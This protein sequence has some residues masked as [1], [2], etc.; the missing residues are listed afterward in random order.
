MDQRPETRSDWGVGSGLCECGCGQPAPI[1]KR[2]RREKGHV[3]GFP[4]RFIRGHNGRQRDEFRVEDR[5][6]ETPCWIWTKSLFPKTGYAQKQAD[7]GSALAH[8]W[9]FEQKHG[10]IPEDKVLDHLCRQRDCVNP[11]HLEPV[12]HAK[13]VQRGERTKLT[14]TEV[15]RI[16]AEGRATQD[17]ADELGVSKWTLYDILS[18]RSWSEAA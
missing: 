9:Y 16:R 5:G 7:G 8:R 18:G 3:R 6:Y 15:D 1:L 13:N 10:P 14:R 4:A 12:T 2:T 11:D 17:L